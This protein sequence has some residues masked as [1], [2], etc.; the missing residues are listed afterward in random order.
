MLIWIAFRARS[1]ITKKEAKTTQNRRKWNFQIQMINFVKWN[2][3]CNSLPGFGNRWNNINI[4]HFFFI[5]SI[6]F[7][8]SS[9]IVSASIQRLPMRI[10]K[11]ISWMKTENKTKTKNMRKG[12]SH[13]QCMSDEMQFPL[14]HER[15]TTKIHEIYKFLHCQSVRD[16]Q[17]NI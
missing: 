2:M 11:W 14:A 12:F 4:F 10:A 13:Q 6:S 17:N 8:S 15:N 9:F 5:C 7:F 16:I 3:K 1:G